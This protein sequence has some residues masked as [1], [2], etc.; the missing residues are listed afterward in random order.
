MIVSFDEISDDARIWIYQSNKLFSNDQ[1]KKIK[2]RIQDFLNSWTSHGNEL[3]VASK[4]K[5]SHFIIIALD[6]NTSLATG[7]SIDKMV[8]FI[9]NL[10]NEF[11][12]RLLDRLDI[13]FKINNEI[14]VANLKDFK[15]KILE[16]K[17]DNT[18]IVFNN[19]I[20]LK[21]DLV[22]NWEIPLSK[23]WHKQLI[24]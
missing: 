17:I 2:D 4:I 8:H 19:L 6:Q 1:V 23:S 7:C 15:H 22:Y 14:F 18:T 5:Y 10:E 11:A 3:K 24:K 20:N 9:K 16:K 13:S 21:S 12:V